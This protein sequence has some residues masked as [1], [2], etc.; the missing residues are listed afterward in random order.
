MSKA[1]PLSRTTIC[2]GSPGYDLHI[3]T[4][5][6]AVKASF[7]R[8]HAA[9]FHTKDFGEELNLLVGHNAALSF[10]VGE[11]VAGHVA[12]KQLQFPDKFVLR[13]TPLVSKFCDVLANYICIAVHTH[14]KK[15][16]AGLHGGTT[17]RPRVI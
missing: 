8:E 14:L 16:W 4:N 15:L 13:P 1:R 5:Q 7:V 3:Q 6:P 17:G 11:D 12:P 2:T 9:F 10:D